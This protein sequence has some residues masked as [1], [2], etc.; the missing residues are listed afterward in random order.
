MTTWRDARPPRREREPQPLGTSLERLAR[1]IGAPPPDVLASVFAG[2]EGLVGAQVAAHAQPR[3]LRDGILVI[4]VDQPAWATQLRLLSA[5]ILGRL[6][7]VVGG[8]DTV[9]EL[10]VQVRGEAPPRHRP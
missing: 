5:D 8:V 2:W 1:G 10:R 9:R 6:T 7:E 4:A 3:S